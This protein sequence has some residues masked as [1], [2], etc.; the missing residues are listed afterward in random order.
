MNSVTPVPTVFRAK[1]PKSK[2]LLALCVMPRKGDVKKEGTLLFGRIVRA[3]PSNSLNDHDT[4]HHSPNLLSLSGGIHSEEQ[5]FGRQQWRSLL[6]AHD[7]ERQQNGGGPVVAA[8]AAVFQTS[9]DQR[10][11]DLRRRRRSGVVVGRAVFQK[12]GPELAVTMVVFV[13]ERLL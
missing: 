4:R 11:N 12:P 6:P 9:C 8:A 7:R 3:R 10:D 2:T 13:R 1:E 5:R